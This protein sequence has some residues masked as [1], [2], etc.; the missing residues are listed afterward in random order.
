MPLSKN[1]FYF[2]IQLSSRPFS[3]ATLT[4]AG[5]LQLLDQQSLAAGVH[6]TS[7]FAGRGSHYDFAHANA[8]KRKLS[9]EEFETDSVP[10]TFHGPQSAAACPPKAD[11]LVFQYFS[12]PQSQLSSLRHQDG[13]S[14]GTN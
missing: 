1:S 13:Q 5:L 12:V 11:L 7:L 2:E 9:F 4:E 14:H 8:C 10:S 3:E 6:H